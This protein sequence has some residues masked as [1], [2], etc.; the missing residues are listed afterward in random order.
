M[1]PRSSFATR[2]L[3]HRFVSP[4]LRDASWRAFAKV[5]GETLFDMCPKENMEILK[6]VA[7]YEAL[8]PW[9]RKFTIGYLTVGT[10]Y[11]L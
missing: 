9:I 2:H 4:T 10:S 3:A 7:K 11:P 8:A 1:C 6:A 5:V